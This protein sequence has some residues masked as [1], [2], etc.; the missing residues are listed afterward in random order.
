MIEIKEEFPFEEVQTITRN[1]TQNLKTHLMKTL[2]INKLAPAYKD[3]VL[4]QE[5][6]L[7]N[8][9][10][11]MA[12]A[13]WK[14]KHSADQLPKLQNLTMRPLTAAVEDTLSNLPDDIIE[15]CISRAK[16]QFISYQSKQFSTKLLQ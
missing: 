2:F 13:M 3:F 14:R 11:N 15:E 7:L 16:E 4:S 9:A 12:R 6:G 10:T 5:P 8:D 1:T